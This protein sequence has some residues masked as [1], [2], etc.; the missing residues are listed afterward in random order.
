MPGIAAQ[1]IHLQYQMRSLNSS[2]ALSGGKKKADPFLN[3]FNLVLSAKS[4]EE[5]PQTKPGSA[6]YRKPGLSAPTRLTLYG[7]PLMN[8]ALY[9]EA[10]QKT[11]AIAVS[12]KIYLLH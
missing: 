10:C 12:P 8:C 1:P 6:G 9:K 5:R 11:W 4:P 2:G 3:P 7:P